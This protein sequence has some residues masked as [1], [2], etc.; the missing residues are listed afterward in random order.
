MVHFF[1]ESFPQNDHTKKLLEPVRKAAAEYLGT[2]I[3]ALPFSTFK[4]LRQT[5]SRVE[6]EADYIAHRRRMNTMTAMALAEPNDERWLFEL[7]DILWAVCDEYTW[8][9]P[10][11]IPEGASPDE[12]IACL[13]LFAC[14]TGCALSEILD[15][16]GERLHPQ[17]RERIEHALHER[18]IEPFLAKRHRNYG[19]N[20]WAAVCGGCSAAVVLR[21][22]TKE[23]AA[24][25]MEHADELMR[26]FLASYHDDGCCLEGSLYWAYGFGY[27]CYYAALVRDYTGGKID[28]F[29]DEKI[30]H[31][32]EF[33]QKVYLKDTYVIPF[34]DAPH[35]IDFHIGLAHFL[36]KEYDTVTL[37]DER[38]EAQFDDDIRYRFCDFIRDFY[39]YDP[40]LSARPLAENGAYDFR[41]AQWMI[42]KQGTCVFAAK[43]GHNNEPHNHNDVGSFLLFD[44]GRYI[45]DD[46][47]WPEYTSWYFGPRRLENIC[48]CSRGH[49]LPIIGGAVQKSGEAYAARVLEWD[50]QTFTLDLSKAYDLPGVGVVRRLDFDGEQI[51]L[52]DIFTGCETS[53]VR[54]RFVTRC[55]PEVQ[56]N[57]VSIEGWTI[58]CEQACH[59]SVETAAF[60]PRMSICKMD[61]KPVETAYLIDF[62]PEKP[63]EKLEFQISKK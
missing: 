26:D 15:L 7:E 43:G 60:E 59:V 5:G 34:A 31:I 54:E 3:A 21:L 23:Q 38:F 42:R 25:A 32:A 52:C 13:D 30:R 37:P 39:W 48:A 4:L 35:N 8:A 27:F 45:L 12:I 36:A 10:A 56:G 19:Q 2:P 11:H 61:M 49:S 62:V 29:R 1:K 51:K 17:V 14:E 63:E 28:W 6:Y 40:A 18:I 16:L 44:D 9:L 57:V 47:G 33:R 24:A 53:E 20:N 22:G 55:V 46:L 50:E 58:T 41:D